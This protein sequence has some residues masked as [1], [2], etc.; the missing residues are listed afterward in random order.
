MHR[1]YGLQNESLR[2][3]SQYIDW[4]RRTF[5]DNNEQ[6]HLHDDWQATIQGNCTVLK[7]ASDLIYLAARIVLA[8]SETEIK[9]HFRAG[10]FSRLQMKLAEY[11]E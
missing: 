1:I 6:Y 10:L 4:P 8:K 3:M 2:T 7:Y 11:P 9:E 5:K